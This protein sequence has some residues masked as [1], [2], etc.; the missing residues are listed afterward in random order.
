[1]VAA[2]ADAQALEQA[3]LAIEQALNAVTAEADRRMGNEAI[4]PGTLSRD[5]L[6]DLKRAEQRR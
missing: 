4:A 6:R 3:R 1:M 5:A 2:N